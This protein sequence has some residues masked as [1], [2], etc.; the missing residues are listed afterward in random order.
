VLA[1]PESVSRAA[2]ERF[3]GA[4]A[5]VGGTNNAAS[6]YLDI[7][8]L[9]GAIEAA[10]PADVRGQYERE[11]QPYVAPL[12]YLASVTRVDGSVAESKAA[13]VVR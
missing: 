7:A 2:A 3:R 5:G 10:M 12:D 4:I 1:L 8:A 6:S 9:R 13:V 11:V